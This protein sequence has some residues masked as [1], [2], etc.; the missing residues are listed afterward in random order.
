MGD[1]PASNRVSALPPSLPPRGLSRPQAA[2][3]V[4]V[5]V[6]TFNEMVGDGRMPQPKVVNSRLIWDR[7]AIDQ[8][9]YALPD[10]DAPKV[11]FAL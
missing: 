6:G 7:L 11:E 3:Y 5:S 2:A 10:K 4:G 1:A 8:A 9:F